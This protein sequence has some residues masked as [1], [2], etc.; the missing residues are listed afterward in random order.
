M[1]QIYLGSDGKTTTVATAEALFPSGVKP[2][3]RLSS[4]YFPTDFVGTGAGAMAPT[5]SLAFSVPLSYDADSNPFVH[6]YH[7]DHDNLDPLF[8]TKLAAG[9]ESWTLNRAVTLT[10]ASSLPGVTD[11]AWGSR[12]WAAP[13]RKS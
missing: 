7:P 5:G 10:F 6:R 8:G 2:T 1:Q 13:T 4:G 3:K 12:C 9:Q 11:P